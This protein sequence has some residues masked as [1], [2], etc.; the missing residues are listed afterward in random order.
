[1]SDLTVGM[2]CTNP[3]SQ[4]APTRCMQ[5]LAEALDRRDDVDVILGS[6][7]INR[8]S[9]EVRSADA[10]PRELE[11]DFDVDLVHW[12]NMMD[13]TIPSRLDVPAVLTYH[14][15]VQWSEP[16]LNYGRFPRVRSVKERLVESVKWRMFDGIHY[17]SRDV[18]ERMWNNRHQVVIPHG[19]P[20]HIN[21]DAPEAYPDQ[22]VVHVS[23]R[24]PRK[25]PDGIR[26]GFNAA[27][28]PHDLVVAGSGWNLPNAENLGYVPDDELSSLY[29]GAD[30]LV[31][32]SYHECF[33]LPVI[34]AIACGT[35]P[36]I[37]DRYSLPE[38]AGDEGVV[39]DPD[40]PED[41]GRG[42]EEA[43]EMDTEP[44]IRRT[45]DDVAAE[46][47]EFYRDITRS[48]T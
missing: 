17:A 16:H 48:S 43:V 26:D 14:G 19:V 29:V 44:G 36:V 24:S 38:V 33:G 32:P 2:W 13:T 18:S 42:I 12:N 35:T 23:A 31:F 5:W 34:E 21:P 46:M 9:W 10:S 47:S 22:Y 27:D 45:W 40:D 39:V 4:A 1:M 3:S 37:S 30:A 15:D 8:K 11:S 41:I 20:P 25:N 28:V 7:S 6:P